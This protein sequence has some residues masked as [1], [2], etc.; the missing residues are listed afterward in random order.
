MFFLSCFCFVFLYKTKYPIN[1]HNRYRYTVEHSGKCLVK[2]PAQNLYRGP[3]FH[4]TK[5]KLLL[6][7]T[8]LLRLKWVA[9]IVKQF[10]ESQNKGLVTQLFFVLQT[11]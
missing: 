3:N 5:Q 9:M 1:L 4:S 7:K 11:A 2:S 6:I 8:R 10:S